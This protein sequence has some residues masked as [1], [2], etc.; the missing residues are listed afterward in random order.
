MQEGVQLLTVT[1]R[2]GV[3]YYSALE[4]AKALGVSRATL[5]RL[6]SKFQR[7]KK[8]RDRKVYYRVDDIETLKDQPAEMRPISHIAAA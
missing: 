3:Q 5:D 1:D 7:Y 6:A 2:E 4:A 8:D